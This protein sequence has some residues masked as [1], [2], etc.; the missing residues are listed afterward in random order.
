MTTA[1]IDDVVAELA[2][3]V[4]TGPAR[5]EALAHLSGC[6]ACARQVAELAEAADA[7]L[8]AVPDT[9]PPLGFEARVVESI[10]GRKP[11]PRRARSRRARS[12]RRVF[13]ALAVAAGLIAVAGVGSL[14]AIDR[15]QT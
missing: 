15:D 10:S 1:H 4:L 12:R 6:A 3:G 11:R 9:E 7:V 2:S 13:G 5:G 14:V 8:L